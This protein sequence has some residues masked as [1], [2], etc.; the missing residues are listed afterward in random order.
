[1]SLFNSSLPI[2]P[3]AWQGASTHADEHERPSMRMELLWPGCGCFNVNDGM[4]TVA[5]SDHGR[6]AP[7]YGHM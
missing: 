7:I 5:R 1:M 4:S 2:F 3:S 6:L